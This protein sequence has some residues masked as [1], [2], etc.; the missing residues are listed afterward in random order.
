M[1]VVCYG[2]SNTYGFDPR[3]LF[4]ERYGPKERWV[5][6]LAGRTDWQ[7]VNEGMNG[8]EVP[9]F[10]VQFPVDTDLLIIMLGTNDLLQGRQPNVISDRMNCFLEQIHFKNVLLISPPWLQLGAWVSG[11][12]LVEASKMLSELYYELAQKRH[13]MFVDA[14][15]WNVDILFDG[16]HFS[17]AG[18]RAFADGLYG[19]LMDNM[20]MV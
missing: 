14:A 12:E 10:S 1:K 7:I 6:I 9:A 18:H 19:Y 20:E 8:R 13:L 11:R 4:G 16:V 5:D 2:D 15:E 17:E 3:S